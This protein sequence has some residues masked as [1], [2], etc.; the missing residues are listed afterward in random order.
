[1]SPYRAAGTMPAI[2]PPEPPHMR[3]PTKLILLSLTTAVLGEAIVS[4]SVNFHVPESLLFIPG[5]L[6]LVAA[7]LGA[8]HI[9]NPDL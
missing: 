7:V 8:M 5:L 6:I 2:P 9:L 1:M 3:K 4:A